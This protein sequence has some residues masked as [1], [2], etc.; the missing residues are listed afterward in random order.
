MDYPLEHTVN[1]TK[2]VRIK[3]IKAGSLFTFVATA[4]ASF[5]IPL[6]VF[7]GV[8]SLFG[9]KTI[10]VNGHPV[11]G[12]D[13]FLA[14]LFMAPLFSIILSIIVWF[15]LYLGVRIRGFFSPA[16]IVYVPASDRSA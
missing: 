15:A 1:D 4:I 2:T 7:C 16:T 11:T 13:G 8:L 14:S 9:F 5:F 12:V 10:H 3:R 6:I